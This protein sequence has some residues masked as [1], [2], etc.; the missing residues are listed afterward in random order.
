MRDPTGGGFHEI[1]VIF[2]GHKCR[3][4]LWSLRVILLFF[5]I[6]LGQAKT[7]QWVSGQKG[8]DRKSN[9]VNGTRPHPQRR[10]RRSPRSPGSETPNCSLTSHCS[11]P[12]PGII[13]A[14]STIPG[15][16]R[17]AWVPSQGHLPPSP[18]GFHVDQEEAAQVSQ[19]S[20]Q[21]FLSP[22]QRVSAN[23]RLCLSVEI[24][25]FGLLP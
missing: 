5:T 22:S 2:P 11:A 21:A 10:E 14:S 12:S 19:V 24:F 9:R 7:T 18:A 20:L 13:L 8:V 17:W 15:S 16:S 3:C 1:T 6:P 23:R 25:I 4:P